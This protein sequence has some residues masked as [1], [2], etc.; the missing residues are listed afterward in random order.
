MMPEA[1]FDPYSN[2]VVQACVLRS[3][4]T[5]PTTPGTPTT[6]SSTP[7]KPVTSYLNDWSGNVE[8]RFRNGNLELRGEATA[9]STSTKAKANPNATAPIVWIMDAEIMPMIP[10]TMKVSDGGGSYSGVGLWQTFFSPA[11][12]G[13]PQETATGAN[14][15]VVGAQAASIAIAPVSF[16]GVVLPI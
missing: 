15:L 6:P 9:P 8:Y 11:K 1:V 4:T 7:W 14:G 3:T 2:N 16:T 13:I 5:T 10:S 12:D